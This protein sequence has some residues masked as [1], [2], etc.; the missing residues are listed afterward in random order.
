[1]AKYTPSIICFKSTY[2]TMF[3]T[4]ETKDKLFSLMF[5]VKTATI[6]KKQQ[7]WVWIA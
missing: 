6:K 4:T 5:K 3:I 7:I 2:P 1:M